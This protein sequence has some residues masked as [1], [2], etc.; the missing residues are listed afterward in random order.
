MISTILVIITIGVSLLAF[1]KNE[2][3]NKMIFNPYMID[4]HKQW[5]RFITS[6]FIHADII[7]LAVN[8]FVLFSFGGIIEN[9]FSVYFENR[10]DY[11]FILLYF[12]GLITAII[13]TFKKNK[14]NM[15]YNALG[16]SGA[17]SAVIFAFV[18]LE[19]M[20][21]ICLYGLL[22]LPSIVFGVAY[23]IYCYYMDKKGGDNVNH[24]AHLWGGLFGFFFTVLLK[25]D[26]LITFFQKLIY[27]RDVI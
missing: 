16:A 9:Y 26:L 5:Y 18:L 27:F 15:Y 21:K 14:D 4:K 10:A 19:P 20:Q 24:D 3:M 25:P 22:C 7:H 8:M 11:Y 12:G 17:V 6:G 13:P 1:S 23:L 2:Y